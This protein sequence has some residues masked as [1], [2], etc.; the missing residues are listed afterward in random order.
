LRSATSVLR[1]VTTLVVTLALS[2]AF[3][4]ALG[5]YAVVSYVVVGQRRATAI[6]TVLGAS[7][8]YLLR[9]QLRNVG[10]I[11]AAAAPVGLAV[12]V[13]GA[14]V[15]ESLIYGVAL[16]DLGSLLAAATLA[17]VAALVATYV[18]ARRAARAD[19]LVSLQV[20]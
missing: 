12:A 11:L 10:L 14:E 4:A 7:P 6:R 3:L 16:R 8:G 1:A 15:L 9:L 18:P 2:A 20:D 13:L 5:M 17:A 19:P